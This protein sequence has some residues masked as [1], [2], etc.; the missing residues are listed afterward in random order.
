M[1]TELSINMPG[2][3]AIHA[4]AVSINGCGVLLIGPSGCG[5]S[6]LALRLID[7]GA[8][9]ICDDGVIVKGS[10]G[11]PVLNAVPTING[12]LEVRGF[13]IIDM[14]FVDTIPLR[15]CIDLG[16]TPQRMPDDQTIEI[17]GFS[18]PL[19][20]LMA[21]EV[22]APLKVEIALRSVSARFS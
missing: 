1:P 3:K 22:S 12:K 10:D 19:L 20:S 8:V 2:A 17:E 16:R 7:R 4:T 9:L 14:P 5:K 11:C 6:D 15:L 21:F 13:G 18:V